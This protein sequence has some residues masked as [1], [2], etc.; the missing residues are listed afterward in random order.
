MGQLSASR[1]LEVW[2]QG[3]AATPVE[4]A[5]LLLSA[6]QAEESWAALSKL[7]IGTRDA[8]LLK[9][10]AET[11]G[12][13]LQA[14]CDCP[15]CGEAA[16]ISFEA[17]DI[18][19]DIPDEEDELFSLT[20]GNYKVYFRLPD[21]RDLAAT[22]VVGDRTL[23]A[24]QLFHRCV[25]EARQ[26][27]KIVSSDGLPS[28]VMDAVA[29]RISRI[30]AQSNIELEMTCPACSHTWIS[31]FDIVAFFWMEISSWAK[32]MLRDIHSLACAYGWSEEAILALSP[33]RRQAYLE[34]V[35]G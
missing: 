34:M 25:I 19:V 24:R 21:S 30:D 7:S 33:A 26:D 12:S 29:E 5:L 22:A 27:D 4:R 14:I 3:L 17:G 8:R 18:L 28:D 6:D 1:L 13:S 11:F 31:H 35:S 9:L 16:E 20:T 10:R 15:H 23:A 2:E 32:R